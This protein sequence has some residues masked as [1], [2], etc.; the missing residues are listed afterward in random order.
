MPAGPALTAEDR[1]ALLRHG[2]SVVEEDATGERLRIGVT[3]VNCARVRDVVSRRFGIDV[4]VDVLGELPRRLRPR[5]C[6]GHRER[7]PG[8]LQVRFVVRGDEHI[9]DILVAED[10]RTVVV[11]ATVCTSVI[12]ECG[13]QCDAPWHVYLKSP[14]AGRVVVDGASGDVVPYVNAFDD[15]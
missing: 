1:V 11:F 10:E 15:D 4:D 2:V 6:V 7:E 3:G 12:G 13:D 9:D 14:L 5:R 8:R